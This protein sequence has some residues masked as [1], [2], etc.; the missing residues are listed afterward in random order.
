MIIFLLMDTKYRDWIDL[1]RPPC[2]QRDDPISQNNLPII[3][4]RPPFYL[5][6]MKGRTSFGPWIFSFC[7]PPL[8][9]IIINDQSLMLV[10]AIV[11]KL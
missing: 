9:V 1:G 4:S 5:Y 10:Y 7:R 11:K 2:P 6:E 3:P 8:P